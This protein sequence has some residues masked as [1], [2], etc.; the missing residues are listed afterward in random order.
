MSFRVHRLRD[1]IDAFKKLPFV[2]SLCGIYMFYCEGLNRLNI[3][4]C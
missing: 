4:I 1:G 3:V 2:I